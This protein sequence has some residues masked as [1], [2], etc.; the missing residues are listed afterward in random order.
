MSTIKRIVC[1]VTTQC[2]RLF[3]I[4]VWPTKKKCIK[5]QKSVDSPTNSYVTY[6]N[7]CQVPLQPVY[8]WCVCPKPSPTIY[9]YSYYDSDWILI[10]MFRV[11]F[12]LQIM[13]TNGEKAE[14]ALKKNGVENR[15][16]RG[17]SHVFTSTIIP[18]SRYCAYANQLHATPYKQNELAWHLYRTLVV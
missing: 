9:L 4:A 13:Q 2:S 17:N 3:R 11:Q 16:R 18:F 8:V 14:C 12:W 6:T 7:M 15:K 5:C 1:N 10:E